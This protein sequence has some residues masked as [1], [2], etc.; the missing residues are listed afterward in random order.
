MATQISPG[1]KYGSLL[2]LKILDKKYIEPSGKKRNICLA[3][4]D[5][6]NE[7]ETQTSYVARRFAKGK[8][9][10]NECANAA[11]TVVKLNEVFGKLKVIGFTLK[12]NRKKAVCKCECG[13][14]ITARPE[15]LVKGTTH[16]CGCI[17][18]GKWEGKISKTL[19]NK[20]KHNAK[21]RGLDFKI[22][23][24]Y[25]WNVY[26]KQKGKCAFTD[27]PIS[28]SETTAGKRTASVDRINNKLGYITGNIQW[29]HKDIN[30][31]R[32]HLTINE[33][34]SLCKL[35][36]KKAKENES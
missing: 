22:D 32:N 34:I 30:L 13:G 23:L 2:I 16:H 35:V 20:I 24:Q 21:K 28:F 15:L 33:F 11:R 4:C 25:L 6:G 12:K 19:L 18:R 27:V 7:F 10:C 9:R 17:K 31:M 5:C 3:K 26:E 14:T 8:A 36:A 1:Q 29:V